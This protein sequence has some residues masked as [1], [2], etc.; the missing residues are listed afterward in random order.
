MMRSLATSATGMK[1]QQLNVDTIANN[2]ANVNTPSF[3]K[4]QARFQD[5]MYQNLRPAGSPDRL[6]PPAP[7]AVGHGTMLA[8]TE[9]N[10]SQG[11]TQQTGNPLHLLIEGDGYFQFRLTDGDIG[12]S[13][14]G[15]LFLSP[16]GVL[17]NSDGLFLEPQMTV[18]DGT[19]EIFV[20]PD[21]VVSVTFVDSGVPEEIGQVELA[22][23]L[24][25]QG[26]DSRGR[27]LYTPTDASGFPFFGTPGTEGLGTVL[28][29]FLEG[30]NVEVVEEMVDLI[31]AQRAYEINSKAIQT[32]DQMLSIAAQLVR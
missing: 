5:L 29:G 14:D 31:T 11:H 28:Q 16:E 7:L 23:F 26:L 8:A 21:G 13:R 17:V 30:S 12:Y 15:S 32:A 3:K 1:A 2:L 22:R 25:P 18:P 10:H 9:R 4:T 24:N 27:N 6:G 20:S 19:K